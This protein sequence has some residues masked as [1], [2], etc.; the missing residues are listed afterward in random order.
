MDVIPGIVVRWNSTWEPYPGANAYRSCV[1]DLCLS[2][3]TDHNLFGEGYTALQLGYPI[4]AIIS[5]VLMLALLTIYMTIP[6]NRTSRNVFTCGHAISNIIFCMAFLFSI[7]E[8]QRAKTGCY[9][10]LVRAT[11]L[12]VPRCAASGMLFVFG[13]LSTRYWLAMWIAELHFKIVWGRSLFKQ[14]IWIPVAV[15]TIVPLALACIALPYYEYNTGGMC[16]PRL[17]TP[18]LLLLELPLAFSEGIAAILQIWTF[19]KIFSILLEKRESSS[20]NSADTSKMTYRERMARK[21]SIPLNTPLLSA[22]KLSARPIVFTTL[23]LLCTVFIAASFFS[24]P[25]P[26]ERSGTFSKQWQPSIDKWLACVL[27]DPSRVQACAAENNT[28]FNYHQLVVAWYYCLIMVIGFFFLCMKMD[29]F[30]AI[31]EI[32]TSN[33]ITRTLARQ[34]PTDLRDA[35]PSLTVM[36]QGDGLES[37]ILSVKTEYVSRTDSMHD[38]ADSVLSSGDVKRVSFSTS[39]TSPRPASRPVFDHVNSELNAYLVAVSTPHLPCSPEIATPASPKSSDALG[40]DIIQYL[41]WATLPDQHRP[42]LGTVG[43]PRSRYSFDSDVR[44]YHDF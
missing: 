12:R 22:L 31:Q 16:M 3:P 38:L 4:L 33:V 43:C 36:K 20:M 8:E 34:Q 17:G 21:V 23:S 5:I 28:I 18:I 1:G 13:V 7:N 27:A 41:P 40:A 35:N 29:T 44:P 14:R 39:L 42:A 25:V 9:D 11:G 2:C 24:T 26:Q 15:A 37:N 30:Y 10:N 32:M 6:K 19:G